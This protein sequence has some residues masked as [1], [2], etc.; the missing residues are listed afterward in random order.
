MT[1]LVQPLETG[2]RGSSLGGRDRDLVHDGGLA[3]LQ[4]GLP[5]LAGPR[6][7]E[8][9]QPWFGLRFGH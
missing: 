3:V 1:M 4:Y 5:A 7:H 8:F 6:S 2:H 9:N